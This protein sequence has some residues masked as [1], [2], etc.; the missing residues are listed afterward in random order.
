MGGA[1]GGMAGPRSYSE[2]GMGGNSLMPDLVGLQR[3]TPHPEIATVAIQG[4]I[5]IFNKPDKELLKP[6]TD[7]SGGIAQAP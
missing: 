3:F 6:P 7:E 2:G 5:Y 4:V 1:S